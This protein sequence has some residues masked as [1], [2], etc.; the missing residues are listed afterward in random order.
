LVF[1]EDSFAD[2]L[3]DSMAGHYAS[4][5]THFSQTTCLLI[6]LS[7]D[8][9]TLKH[10]LRA[11]A[12]SFP[13]H[14]HYY[15][16]FVGDPTEQVA[17]CDQAQSEANFEVFNLI[18]LNLTAD[19]INALARLISASDNDFSGFA[20][21]HVKHQSFRF[22][23]VGS[24][25]AGKST[26]VSHFRSMLTQ[27]EWTEERAPGMEKPA[28]TLTPEETAAI[29][30]W[31]AS[32]VAKK[33][34]KLLQTSDHGIHIV[35][36]A[37]LDA[38]AFT[39]QDGWSEKAERLLAAVSPGTYKKRELAAGHVIFLKG[40]PEIMAQRAISLN[41]PQ[42]SETL[43]NQQSELLHIYNHPSIKA[44]VTIVDTTGKTVTEVVQEVADIVFRKP[45]EE[46]NLQQRLEEIEKKG[47]GA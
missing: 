23:V 3:I 9:P 30:A 4:L 20:E 6:G 33:N 40:D 44:G 22:Y 10:L 16:N 31:V 8:D 21:E 2:Q 45:Y 24:V 41:K 17:E 32:Q 39:P 36:R 18:T 19:E 42:S 27:D 29:D 35:D 5:A 26:T 15:I 47:H 7:L 1:S 46:A 34:L 43:G 37:P 12:N 14:F 13:G 38:F 11:S 28:N 25:G